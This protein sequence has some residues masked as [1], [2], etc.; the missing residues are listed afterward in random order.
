MYL[1]YVDESGEH[2]LPAGG[3]HDG[4]LSVPGACAELIHPPERSEEV[5][6]PAAASALHGGDEG[7]PLRRRPPALRLA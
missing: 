5:F 4:I 7:Q 3:R 2:L 6:S 1:M